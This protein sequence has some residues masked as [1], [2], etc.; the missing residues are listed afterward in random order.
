MKQTL[1]W[2]RE[3]HSKMKALFQALG[4]TRLDET[5]ERELLAAELVGILWLHFELNDRILYPALQQMIG[6]DDPVLDYAEGLQDETRALMKQ[7][8]AMSPEDPEW[9]DLLSE[10]K[11]AVLQH[12]QD[13]EAEVCARLEETRY[14]LSLLNQD[15]ER[16]REQLYD[17]FWQETA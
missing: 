1:N 7:L 6:R 3:D 15:I 16:Q 10:L 14:D 13:E 12:I 8:E 11:E 2:L 4:D 5:Q 9:E 17:E